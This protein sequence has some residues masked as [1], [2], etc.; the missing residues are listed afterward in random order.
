VDVCP[1]A[2]LA[3]EVASTDDILRAATAAVFESWLERLAP[4]F[5]SL[6]VS[7][8]DATALAETTLCALEGGF[9]LARSRR[10]G[11]VL[12][13]LGQHLAVSVTA[14]PAHQRRLGVVAVSSGAAE[15]GA[16]RRAR[17]PPHG[18][19]TKT[20][21]HHRRNVRANRR[22]LAAGSTPAAP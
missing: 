11:S 22:R 3:L 7:A 15:H 12:V 5:R 1:I 18:A 6:G 21:A 17:R 9:M 8:D 13:R 2:T 4:R 10:D 20:L 19:A 16:D 14:R